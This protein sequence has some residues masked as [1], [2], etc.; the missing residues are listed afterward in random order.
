[1]FVSLNDLLLVAAMSFVFAL[2]S[3]VYI[4]P[5]RIVLKLPLPYACNI[6]LRS[7]TGVP[8]ENRNVD[9]VILGKSNSICGHQ[10]IAK[11]VSLKRSV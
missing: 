1:V 6:L 9:G 11:E 3:R 7:A 2:D 5:V 4:D 8:S 10:E